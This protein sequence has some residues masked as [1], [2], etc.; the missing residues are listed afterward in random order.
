MIEPFPSFFPSPWEP[1]VIANLVFVIRDGRILLIRKKRGLGAGKING[2]G[3]KLELGETALEA[4][5]RETEEELRIVPKDLVEAGELFFDFADG[6]KLHCFVFRGTE[7]EGI[8]TETDEA[9]PEWYSLD[10]IPYDQ[11]WPD[12]IDWLPLVINSRNFRG[13]YRFSGETILRKKVLV[14]PDP[15]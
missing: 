1:N 15:N 8:P 9:F 4:A 5:V 3:G 11:M 10:S 6:L 13:W 7:F 14:L 2:P 12:D